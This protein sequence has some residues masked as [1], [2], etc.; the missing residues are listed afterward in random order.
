MKNFAKLTIFFSL[1]FIAIFITAILLSSVAF[2]VN[3][4]RT[5]SAEAG[6]GKDFAEV[7]WTAVS[8]ALYFSILFGLSYSARKKMPVPVSIFCITV[9]AFVFTTGASLGTGRLEA[10]GPVFTP[11]SP[12]QAGPGLMLSRSENTVVLLRESRELRGPRLVSIPNRPFIYQEV[13]LGPNNTILSL[14]AL[15]F[16]N[17]VP[18]FIRSIGI[19]FSLSAGQLKTLFERSFLFYAAYALSLVLLL[20]SLRF[21]L[22]LSPWPLANIFLVAFVFRMILSFEIFLNAGEINN[23][24]ASFLDKRLPSV[25]LTPLVFAALSILILLYTFLAGVARSGKKKSK[26]E[27]ND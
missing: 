27:W 17:S 7:V 3:S 4:T 14:P 6:A 11:A 22:G 20:S 19:D 18:W 21:L 2:W 24:I 23:M 16:G 25:F 13:P 26:R 15:L 9:L 12:V 10:L 8:A 1:T 5:I